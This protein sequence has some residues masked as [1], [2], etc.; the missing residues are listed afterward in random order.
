MIVNNR[1]MCSH[2]LPE[3]IDKLLEECK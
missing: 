2:M 1:T 3:Q